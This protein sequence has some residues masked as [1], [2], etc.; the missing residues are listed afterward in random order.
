M[1]AFARGE[2]NSQNILLNLVHISEMA[3]SVRCEISIERN[4]M[5]TGTRP[6]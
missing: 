2:I 5:E 3:E 4:E 6:Q 1:H